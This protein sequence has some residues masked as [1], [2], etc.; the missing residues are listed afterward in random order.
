MPSL[1]QTPAHNDVL[2]GLSIS[3][4][5]GSAITPGNLLVA[6]I[7]SHGPL[8]SPVYPLSGTPDI[9]GSQTAFVAIV[10]KVAGVGE[11]T[12]ITASASIVRNWGLTVY[13]VAPDS[14]RTWLGLDKTASAGANAATSL[15]VGP[16]TAQAEVDDFAACGF[17][18]SLASAA[19]SHALT[20]GYTVDTA[21]SGNTRGFAGRKLLTGSSAATSSTGSWTTSVN[22]AA[23][24]ATY[25]Q[26]APPVAASGAGFLGLL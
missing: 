8:T 10:S 22:A 5:L 23:A 21:A 14:G 17:G 18:F 11:S 16:T 26:S 2:N 3:A 7:T 4:T 20:S 9:T 1:A 12:T 6:V 15:A 25:K 13:E 24:L 19:S